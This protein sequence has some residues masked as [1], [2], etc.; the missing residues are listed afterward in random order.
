MC[1]SGNQEGGSV[2]LIKKASDE[3]TLIGGAWARYHS[4]L[5]LTISKWS[6]KKVP[7]PKGQGRF[8]VVP[9]CI[10]T[11]PRV[12][13]EIKKPLSTLG[14]G[15]DRGTTLHYTLMAIP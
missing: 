12:I 7:T 13:P 9:P 3:N 10:Y 4:G 8:C 1:Y 5:S 6:K 14:Q 2:S 11:L 15:R